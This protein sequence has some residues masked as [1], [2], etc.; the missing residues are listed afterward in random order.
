MNKFSISVGI[1]LARV[2]IYHMNKWWL[3][4]PRGFNGLRY[5][6]S[7][8][9][10][11]LSHC[12]NTCFDLLRMKTSIQIVDLINLN[13]GKYLNHCR[14]DSRLV[15]SQWETSLQSKAVSHWLGT[16]SESTLYIWLLLPT[17][18]PLAQEI[19]WYSLMLWCLMTHIHVVFSELGYHWLR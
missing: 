9:Q 2:T 15:P 6:T 16:N 8:F 12:L 14:A 4:V 7:L 19:S 11:N 3:Y 13:L 10:A 18:S 1:D 17:G 5:S